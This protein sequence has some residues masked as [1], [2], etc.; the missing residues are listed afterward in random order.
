MSRIIINGMKNKSTRNLSCPWNHLRPGEFRK[1]VRRS[2]RRS[3][4]H[5]PTILAHDVFLSGGFGSG[6]LTQYVS[7][8]VP[9]SSSGPTSK[10]GDRIVE[11]VSW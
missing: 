2:S 1:V 8:F 9:V 4:L 11:S 10:V 5:S 3:Y 6:L 7:L